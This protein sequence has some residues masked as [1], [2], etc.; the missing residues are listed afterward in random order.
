MAMTFEQVVETV[1]QFSPKQRE[2]LSDLMG[3]WEIKAVRHEIARDAQES[4]TMFSQGK[5]KPQS[6]QNAIKE[7]PENERHAYE[8]YRD[9]LHYEASMFESSYT[10]AVMEGRKEGLLEG[11]LE[12]IKEGEKKK[13][14]QIARNLLKTG[15]L[16]V[17]S[18]AA[19]TDLSIEDIRIM[20]TELGNS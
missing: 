2:I 19:M 12:G 5:L 4:L 9:N 10:A 16:N 3:K 18:I 7:L 6:A 14:M 1:K 20:Q 15:G 13:A 8:R 17:Q 11:K